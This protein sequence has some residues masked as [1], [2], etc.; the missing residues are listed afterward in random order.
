MSLWGEPGALP[1]VDHTVVVDVA[2]VG[3]A[4]AHTP[5]L[6]DCDVQRVLPALHQRGHPSQSGALYTGHY[7]VL[8]K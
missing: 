6:L 3:T 4:P 8:E 2:A 5:V 7:V 1:K